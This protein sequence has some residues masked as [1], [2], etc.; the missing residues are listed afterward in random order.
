M[1]KKMVYDDLIQLISNGKMETFTTNCPKQIAYDYD[2]N[3]GKQKLCKNYKGTPWCHLLRTVTRAHF[4]INNLLLA[5]AFSSGSSSGLWHLFVIEMSV[6]HN[7]GLRNLMKSVI[8]K[9][10]GYFGLYFVLFHIP[11]Q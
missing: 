6:L 2:F 8:Q 11:K 9:T 7:Y 5:F 10:F 3:E 1:K 4:K